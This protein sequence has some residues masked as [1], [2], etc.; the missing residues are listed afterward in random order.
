MLAILSYLNTKAQCKNSVTK[1]CGIAEVINIILWCDSFRWSICQ[2]KHFF[3]QN[4]ILIFW[5]K[6]I[7]VISENY[8]GLWNYNIEM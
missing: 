2:A 3:P 7:F 5:L 1:I 4:F 6:V 8:K